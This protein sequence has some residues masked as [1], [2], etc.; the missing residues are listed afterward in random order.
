MS[1]ETEVSEVDAALEIIRRREARRT[2]VNFSL[3]MVPEEP[4]AEHHVIVCDSLDEIANNVGKD[5]SQFAKDEWKRDR[6]MIFQPPGTAKSSYASVRFPAYYVG[7]FPNKSIIHGSYGEGLAT[8]FGRKVRTLVKDIKYNLL[9]NTRLSEDAQAK[10]EWETDKGG[11]YFAAGVGSGITGRRGDL[12]IIDDPVKG[13]AEA[14]RKTIR[15]ECWNWYKSDFFTRLKPGAAQVIIQ[16]RWHVDDLS[17]RILPKDWNGESGDFIGFDGEVWRVICMAAEAGKNDPLGRAEG[18]WLW[19]DFFTPDTWHSIKNVMTAN[20]TTWRE[21]NCLYQQTPQPEEGVYFKRKW[22]ED[23]RYDLG[24]H[25]PV[26]KYGASDYGVKGEG[27]DATEHGVG[28]YDANMDL[29]F[30]D[31]WSGNKMLDETIP[32]QLE[33]EKRH[34]PYA[35]VG[36]VGVIRR[37]AEP[38]LKLHRRLTGVYSRQEWLPHIGDK[39]AHAKTF[40]G[41]ASSG[42][43]HIPRCQWGDELISQL[44]AFVPNTDHEDDK[45]D[46]CGH[47][48]RISE[49]SFGPQAMGVEPEKKQD[50]YGLPPDDDYENGEDDTNWMLN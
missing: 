43:V 16:T 24:E 33:L 6:L 28:G 46:V 14:D 45:V 25:P 26:S 30:I 44:V 29:W 4:P 50:E 39:G 1:A 15:D 47:L 36:E 38:F 37:A 27:G 21:W 9:F 20:G 34:R 41:L 7:K 35:W 32:A 11:S 18:E 48:G 13:R 22:F 23:H 17:G 31:W 19:P 10:G 3:F 40:Q 8:L 12:G 49:T 2:L 5:R 42:K